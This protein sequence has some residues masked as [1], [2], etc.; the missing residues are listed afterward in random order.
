MKQPTAQLMSRIVSL[1]CVG[2]A[3]LFLAS[4]TLR[5][6]WQPGW[7]W[8]A[9]ADL[10]AAVF[11][12]VIAWLALFRFSAQRSVTFLFVGAGALAAA[13]FAAARGLWNVP[14]VMA[15]LPTG[16][17]DATLWAWLFE[18]GAL[19]MGLILSVPF[20]RRQKDAGL[21][22]RHLPT[23]I[24]VSTGAVTLLLLVMW[25]LLPLPSLMHYQRLMNVLLAVGFAVALV[26][27]LR[28][29]NWISHPF[30]YWLVLAIVVDI[31]NHVLFAGNGDV[32]TVV[33]AGLRVVSYGLIF[34]GLL[35]SMAAHFREAASQ[36]AELVSQNIDLQ[37]ARHQLEQTLSTLQAKESELE[38]NVRELQDTKKAML[39][40]LE[41]LEEDRARLEETSAKDEA[42]LASIGEGVVA[43]DE[44]GTIIFM[45]QATA[46]LL[47]WDIAQVTGQPLAKQSVLVE[48]N[49]QPVPIVRHPLSQ[50]L[51]TRQP[52]ATKE[53]SFRRADGKLVAV[54]ITATPVL[55]N[56]QVIGAIEV[57]R[58]IT[59]DKAVDRAKTEF[60]SLASHQLRTPLTTINW[61]TEMLLSGDAGRITKKQHTFLDAIYQGNQRLV[62][63]VNALLNV[64]RMEMGSFV[65]QPELLELSSVARAVIAELQPQLLAK[66][67]RLEEQFAAMPALSMDRNLLHIILQNLLSNAIKYTLED[68]SVRLEIAP[69]GDMVQIMV[70]DNGVGIPAEARPK[71]FTKLFR[72]D[73]VREKVMDGNGLGLY[74]VQAIVQQV[75]GRIWF[76]SP[77]PKGLLP[78]VGKANPGTAFYVTVPL[79][80]MHARAGSKPLIPL[81]ATLPPPPTLKK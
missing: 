53:F 73:N 67:T 40:L 14:T 36:Q 61:Y 55:R 68:G 8:L 80:G 58:D 33:S 28:K 6:T 31:A 63:L 7:L 21:L 18:R 22:P 13:A 78:G 72:A 30:D 46:K 37:A 66:R 15:W 34:G 54:F 51:Q 81:R 35:T 71:I 12:W 64:S 20:W 45:N 27:Y 74:L 3:L 5:L 16:G 25:W 42:L 47:H 59:A 69:Q 62:D 24:V 56:D 65:I 44:A 11:A 50:A 38:H 60:V 23:T 76:V 48:E 52:V 17:A 19:I 1:I 75:G 10:M 57:F 43:T 41:D 26:N 32:A 2:L 29:G 9:S 39:N 77:L 49:G 70:A 4:W 79:L